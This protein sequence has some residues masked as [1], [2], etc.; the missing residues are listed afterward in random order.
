ML[1]ARADEVPAVSV[2]L[3]AA[4]AVTGHAIS[5]LGM[6]HPAAESLLIGFAAPYCDKRAFGGPFD[7]A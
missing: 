6:P 2:N 4:S 5:T 7:V 3:R 1:L